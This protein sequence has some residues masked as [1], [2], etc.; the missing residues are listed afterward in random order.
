LP[1][2]SPDDEEAPVPLADVAAPALEDLETAAE[3]DTI[4]P[5]DDAGA[6]EDA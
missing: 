4:T 6:A 3:E 1:P 2:P 5:A